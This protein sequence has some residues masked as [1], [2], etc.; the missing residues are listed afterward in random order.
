M[1]ILRLKT[2]RKYG[3]TALG[4]PR[5][6]L[7]GK[8]RD[9][10]AA[11]VFGS[12]TPTRS[13]SKGRQRRSGALAENAARPVKG[14]GRA[15]PGTRNAPLLALFEV[16]LFVPRPLLARS[17]WS[18]PCNPTGLPESS[19]GSLRKR[20]APPAPSQ[21]GEFHPEGVADHCA[22]SSG[23][24]SGCRRPGAVIRGSAAEATDPRLLSGKPSAC[25]S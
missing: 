23:S 5:A 22:N 18:A 24:P 2:G 14:S 17:D 3:R 25:G 9:T 12:A 8:A 1:R 4:R 7:A 20:S 13:A 15:R 6:I 16:A 11:S 21:N 10:S 19:R